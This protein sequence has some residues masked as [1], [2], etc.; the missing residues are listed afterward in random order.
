MV[1]RADPFDPDLHS[2]FHAPNGQV[3]TIRPIRAEDAPL[4]QAFIQGLSPQSMYFRFL[5]VFKE[6][7]AAE[8]KRLTNPDPNSELAL[9]ATVRQGDA[10][11][12][13]GVVRYALCPRTDICEFA[14]LVADNWA[15]SGLACHLMNMLVAIARKRGL[16]IMYGDVLG[17]NKR[18][19]QFVSKFGFH[20]LTHPDDEGLRRAVL[21]LTP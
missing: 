3:V 12:A 15:G 21:P 4:E 13:I 17:D 6:F 10:H 20:P 16:K 9:I 11:P 14:I 19:L 7:S 18:M 2:E 8:L 1:Y 5:N